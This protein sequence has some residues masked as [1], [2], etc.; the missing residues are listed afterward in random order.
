MRRIVTG[1][2]LALG[3][4]AWADDGVVCVSKLPPAS[5]EPVMNPDASKAAAR[6]RVRIDDSP[7]QT[8]DAT[9]APRFEGLSRTTSHL[10][11]VAIEQRTIE[12]FT[13]RF[14]GKRQRRLW[15][16]EGY[17]TWSL[18]PDDCEQR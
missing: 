9:T 17:F 11:R 15:L 1:L 18:S 16:K 14:E 12:S 8:V 5:R 7:W 6:Y 10:V 13:F 2:M 3:S 4:A